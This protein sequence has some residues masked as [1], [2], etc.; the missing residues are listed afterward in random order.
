[1]GAT[2]SIQC[3]FDAV[4]EENASLHK[5]SNREIECFNPSEQLLDEA[6]K[7]FG[8]H[9]T[10]SAL[11]S[12]GNGISKRAF[13]ADKEF[14]TSVP[15][16]LSTRLR[17]GAVAIENVVIIRVQDSTLIVSRLLFGE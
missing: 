5:Y 16:A 7:V 13:D 9:R 4:R 14:F 2:R 12:L 15:E 1:M 17:H 8:D 10:F 6:R 3:N 11:V